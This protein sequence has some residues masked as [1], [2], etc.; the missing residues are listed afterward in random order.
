MSAVLFLQTKP[1]I[2]YISEGSLQKKSVDFFRTGGGVNPESTLLK[3][4]GFSRWGGGVLGPIS[5][6][7]CPILFSVAIAT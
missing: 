4:C 2:Q 3:K 6:L 5:T 1:N 7:F